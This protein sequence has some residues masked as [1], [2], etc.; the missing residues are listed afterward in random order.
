MDFGK[1]DGDI[2]LMLYVASD[3]TNLSSILPKSREQLV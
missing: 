3:V 1:E 2:I